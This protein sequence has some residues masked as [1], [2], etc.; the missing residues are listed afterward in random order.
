[1][2]DREHN[3]HV[4]C[5][6][7]KFTNIWRR[8]PQQDFIMLPNIRLHRHTHCPN[9]CKIFCQT[10]SVLTCTKL[11]SMSDNVHDAVCREFHYW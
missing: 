11:H 7:E 2:F 10:S 1:V 3:T 8:R 6:M 5:E 9:S 4:L